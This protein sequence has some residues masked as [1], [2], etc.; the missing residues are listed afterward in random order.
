[1]KVPKSWIKKVNKEI[2][3]VKDGDLYDALHWCGDDFVKS[4]IEAVLKEIL[5]P[6]MFKKVVAV[7]NVATSD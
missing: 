7:F 3:L 4:D 2:P 5:P 6:A 1:M